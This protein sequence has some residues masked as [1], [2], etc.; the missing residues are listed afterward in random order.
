M[1]PHA[2]MRRSACCDQNRGSSVTGG[3]GR[4]SASSE[5]AAARPCSSAAIH[6]PQ[7]VSL[8]L[9]RRFGQ[10]ATT[11]AATT[12]RV[13]YARRFSSQRIPSRM[14]TPASAS[15]SVYGRSPAVT[16]T[17][18][19]AMYSPSSRVSRHRLRQRSTSAT[20]RPSRVSIP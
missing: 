18:S 8:V 11:P 13:P 5:P 17:R 20:R 7:R 3:T 12:S 1:T 15:Q 2:W 9:K 19:A 4:S 16:S 14:S 6:W 10:R